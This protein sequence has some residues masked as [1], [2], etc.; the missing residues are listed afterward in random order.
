LVFAA[1]AGSARAITGGKLDGN[2]HPN[3]GGLVA[4]G[5]ELPGSGWL[6]CSGSLV[7][8]GVFLTAAHCI[9]MFDGVTNLR[10]FVNFSS[11]SDASSLIP[12]TATIDPLYVGWPTVDPDPH[13]FAVVTFDPRK[14]KGIQPVK[15]APLGFLDAAL[16]GK[17][18]AGSD[19]GSNRK[20]RNRKMRG[21]VTAPSKAGGRSDNGQQ[22]QNGNNQQGGNNGQ[23]LLFVNVG[24]GTTSW[25]P[26]QDTLDGLRRSSVSGDPALQGDAF[27][28]LSQ[29]AS[30]GFGGT[31]DGDS[32]G[33]QFLGAYAVSITI[34]GD[35]LCTQY[36]INLRL[37]TRTARDFLSQYVNDNNNS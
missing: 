1:L 30:K 17:A 10:F 36:G 6:G 32:G 3:V 24:Y 31:C 16:K 8:P 22:G 37:D 33:P 9:T 29:D 34:A 26:P 15:L 21:L 25:P 14:A 20:L 12:G 13:D 5:D 28:Q 27:L 18:K 19:H 35:D 11:T 23:G 4:F 2:Q 7:A